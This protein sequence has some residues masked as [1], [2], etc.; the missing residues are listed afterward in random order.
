MNTY[1]GKTDQEVDKYE[2]PEAPEGDMFEAVE[3]TG[4]EEFMALKPWM[5][6]IKEPSNP[7]AFVR[8][9]PSA[10]LEVSF[11]NGYRT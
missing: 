5:G 9:P 8:G 11:V 3:E 6:A 1:I 7:P 2:R 10:K 4:G